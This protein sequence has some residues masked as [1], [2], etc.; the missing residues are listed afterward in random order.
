[1]MINDHKLESQK[2][3][4]LLNL[5]FFIFLFFCNSERKA[6]DLCK[7]SSGISEVHTPQSETA[8]PFSSKIGGQLKKD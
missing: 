4:Y 7:I 5:L 2:G 8:S 6:D 3:K 1:M